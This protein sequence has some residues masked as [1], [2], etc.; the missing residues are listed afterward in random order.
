MP[1]IHPLSQSLINK[2]A[3]GEVIE[4]PASVVKELLENSIDAGATRIDVSVEKGGMERITI[5]DNG[6][7]ISPDDMLLAVTSHATSKLVTDDDLFSVST[8]GFRGEALASVAEISRLCIQS[9]VNGEARP[10]YGMAPT[11]GSRRRPGDGEVLDDD[12]STND[13]PG[14]DQSAALRRRD[15]DGYLSETEEPEPD[16]FFTENPS[17]SAEETS[18]DSPP[19]KNFNKISK[20]DEN[21]DS[22]PFPDADETIKSK[23]SIK[24]DAVISEKQHEAQDFISAFES[25]PAETADPASSEYF[26]QNADTLDWAV[27]GKMDAFQHDLLELLIFSPSLLSFMRCAF[28]ADHFTYLPARELV[29]RMCEMEDDGTTP[30]FERLLM[31]F[32]S[33]KIQSWLVSLEAS[34]SR[35]LERKTPEE[36]K[37]LLGELLEG[38][39]RFRLRSQKLIHTGL[40][41]SADLDGQQKASM[42]EQLIE[43]A[44]KNTVKRQ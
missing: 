10:R 42:L 40:F 8:M 14:D 37:F 43:D 38:Y 39:D 35:K 33:E 23:L 25:V 27:Y 36:Q 31:V 41:R 5:A 20:K 34:A 26:L 6:C 4:R 9:R 7:G 29:T 18:A 3:A 11:L 22:P 17:T 44:R 24:E 16:S 1:K 32:E 30:T 15:D 21:S 28:S 13:A 12:P 19:E 2:I